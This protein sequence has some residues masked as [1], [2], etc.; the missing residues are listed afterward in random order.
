VPASRCAW[1][2]SRNEYAKTRLER[3]ETRIPEMKKLLLAVVAITAFGATQA[4]TSLGA[5]GANLGPRSTV[6]AAAFAGTSTGTS[7]DKLVAR[8]AAPSDSAAGA[9]PSTYAMMFLGLG[10]I[11]LSLR[12]RRNSR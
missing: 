5:D 7:S 3:I 2:T 6:A 10:L 1:N 12:S 8:A 4:A 9:E 11:G